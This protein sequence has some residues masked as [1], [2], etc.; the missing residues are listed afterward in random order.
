MKTGA[1]QTATKVIIE[2]SGST[3]YAKDSGAFTTN[4][5]AGSKAFYTL[6][7][8]IQ[9]LTFSFYVQDSDGLR[10]TANSGDTIRIYNVVSATGGYAD[11]TTVGSVVTLVAVNATE[12]VAQYALGTWDVV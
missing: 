5:G 11:S 2:P 4:E 10:I 6:P 8:A 3:K 7:A 1:I 12:W 9:G